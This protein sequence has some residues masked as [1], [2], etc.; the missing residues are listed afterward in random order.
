LVAFLPIISPSSTRSPFFDQK[1]DTLV[2]TSNHDHNVSR[3][4]TVAQKWQRNR[5][6]V[7][8]ANTN[9]RIKEGL[10]NYE[11]DKGGGE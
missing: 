9:R 10:G 5:I 3:L 2:I 11:G 6:S 7:V 8:G 4:K 1:F